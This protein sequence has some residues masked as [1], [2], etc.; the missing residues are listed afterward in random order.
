MANGT[1]K[2]A[3]FDPSQISDLIQS[4]EDGFDASQ[5]ADLI[6]SP[7][8]SGN[9]GIG[10]ALGSAGVAL[11][12]LVGPGKFRAAQIAAS[13][14]RAAKIKQAFSM[15][16]K[17]GR[18]ALIGDL[19]ETSVRAIS[20]GN[21][22]LFKEAAGSALKEF[23]LSVGLGLPLRGVSGGFN[24][25]TFRP[26]ATQSPEV[27]LAY[28][29]FGEKMEKAGLPPLTLAAATDSPLFDTLD[30]V[31]RAAVGSA[32]KMERFDATFTSVAQAMLKMM[33]DKISPKES[34]DQLVQ[35]LFDVIMHQEKIGDLP[36]VVLRQTLTRQAD[37]AGVAI[38]YEPLVNFIQKNVDDIDALGGFG[39]SA[40]GVTA[41]KALLNITENPTVTN[42]LQLR[43][44]SK[45]VIR[46][47]EADKVT[48]ATPQVGMFKMIAKLS[49]QALKKSLKGYDTLMASGSK[50]GKGTQLLEMLE[51]SDK[52]FAQHHEKFF[53]TIQKKIMKSINIKGGGTPGALADLMLKAERKNSLQFIKSAKAAWPAKEWPRVQ[54]AALWRLT[55]KFTDFKTKKID[56]EGLMKLFSDPEN[57]G[58][59]DRLGKESVETLF[60][61]ELTQDLTEMFKA[62]MFAQAKNPTDVGKVA[63]SISQGGGIIGS[64][65]D[66]L[67]GQ[68][69]DALTTLGV[70]I[71]VPNLVGRLLINKTVVKAFTK[72]LL[73]APNN[74]AWL[75]M[76][77][78]VASAVRAAREAERR[79]NPPAQRVAAQ[80]PALA[81]APQA[82]AF[83]Q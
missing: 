12:E 4:A 64:G 53:N 52:R 76:Y 7:P 50:S 31:A 70:V 16:G 44:I 26:A 2:K 49:D 38:N 19:A 36:A 37:E 28:K 77:A 23:G 51:K 35:N 55:D 8:E 25:L 24:K 30:N 29:V 42:M 81:N 83:Q 17:I 48:A 22:P 14:N 71:G 68:F 18:G 79:E 5:V 21:L 82:P 43:S 11:T 60:G 40:S 72:G 39:A 58:A 66:L 65:A 59:P 46:S 45:A 34:A 74:P 57:L 54:R 62:G 10:S 32:G 78:R 73:M 20:G 33:R 67:K 27:N 9:T 15:E 63:V 1:K 56:F 61:K 80:Q 69:F 75:P 6:A 13:P 47:L 3:E 41:S